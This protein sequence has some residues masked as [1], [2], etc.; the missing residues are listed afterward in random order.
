MDALGGKIAF[1]GYSL[2]GPGGPLTLN[3]NSLS[4][5]A[6]ERAKGPKYRR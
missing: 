5:L 2:P 3:W 1:Q 6:S 4:H